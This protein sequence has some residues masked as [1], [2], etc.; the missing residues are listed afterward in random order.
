MPSE[1]GA[2]HRLMELAAHDKDA[3]KRLGIS[4]SVAREFTEADKDSSRWK[5]REHVTQKAD[6]CPTIAN[7]LSKV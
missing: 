4:Q 5:K 2:Q 6:F 7:L 3:A 1:S